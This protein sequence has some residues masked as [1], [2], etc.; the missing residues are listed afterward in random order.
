M[1]GQPLA[2]THWQGAERVAA[3][4]DERNDNAGSLC[5]EGQGGVFGS[6]IDKPFGAAMPCSLATQTEVAS[7]KR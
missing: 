6:N 3:P 1:D 5:S 2:P 7:L 4:A